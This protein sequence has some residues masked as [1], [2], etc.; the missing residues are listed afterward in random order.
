VETNKYH[1]IKKTVTYAEGKTRVEFF[2]GY[3]KWV[4]KYEKAKLYIKIA[5]VKKAFEGFSAYPGTK[6]EILYITTTIETIDDIAEKEL[7][8]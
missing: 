7:L 6:Y 5:S 1:V 2:K 3:G 8:T 4:S